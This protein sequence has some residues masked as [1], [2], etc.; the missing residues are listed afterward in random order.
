M[1]NCSKKIR[2]LI[3]N[4]L[5]IN[6]NFNSSLLEETSSEQYNPQYSKTYFI[7]DYLLV[8]NIL[9]NPIFTTSEIGF[10]NYSRLIRL[11]PFAK[12]ELKGDVLF[13]DFKQHVNLRNIVMQEYMKIQ[14]YIPSIIDS[15]I[16]EH[17]TPISH[18]ESLDII[19]KIA[20]P[21]SEKIFLTL[22]GLGTIYA[23]CEFKFFRV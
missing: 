7:Y 20:T 12:I 15:L 22:S 8:K 23:Y 17:F 13:S 6:P 1:Q 18:Y 21:L 5:T 19:S 10:G 3:F 9:K 4:D 14:S 2:H 16:Q 11:L